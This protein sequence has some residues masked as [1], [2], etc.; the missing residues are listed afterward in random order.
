MNRHFRRSL[1]FLLSAGVLAAGIPPGALAAGSQHDQTNHYKTLQTMEYRGASTQFRSQSEALSTIFRRPGATTADYEV[2]T[3]G[4][5]RIGR[6]EHL[7]GFE[8]GSD[9]F[10][11]NRET[12]RVAPAGKSFGL[13]AR[14]LNDTIVQVGKR[15]QPLGRW[16][17][18]LTFGLT[19][20]FPATMDFEFSAEA[21]PLQGAAD[22]VVIGF[23]SRR[24][25]TF[26]PVD[27][28]TAQE[29]AS[30]LL[31]G[32]YVWSPSQGT[33]YQSG[34]AFVA[35]RG[36]ETL[37]IEQLMLMTDPKG[38]RPLFIPADL[39]QALGLA[40]G[41]MAVTNEGDL[42]LW[43]KQAVK[44]GEIAAVAGATSAER[45]TNDALAMAIFGASSAD[46]ITDCSAQLIEVAGEP[47]AAA[48]TRQF[49]PSNALKAKLKS[50]MGEDLGGLAGSGLDLAAA[51]FSYKPPAMPPWLVAFGGIAEWANAAA[52]AVV[53]LPVA[54]EKFMKDMAQAEV[55][56]YRAAYGGERLEDVPRAKLLPPKVESSL[57]PPLP[58]PGATAPVAVSS[59]G[60]GTAT[61]LPWVAGGA[62]AVAVLG[63]VGSGGGG[64]DGS[65]SGGNGKYRLY[66]GTQD[67]TIT[68]T[69]AGGRR[70]SLP[71]ELVVGP[72]GR[73]YFPPT[74]WLSVS[75]SGDSFTITFR[76]S[77]HVENDVVGYYRGTIAQPRI[78]G[79]IDGTGPKSTC[80]GTFGVELVGEY[81]APPVQSPEKMPHL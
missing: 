6:H 40:T 13:L 55:E 23:A 57:T 15:P 30:G 70:H 35:S 10:S 5:V 80:R 68:F 29:L 39:R 24:P 56:I 50:L 20:Y 67:Y 74:P 37:R 77:I 60:G 73:L 75:Q 3:L 27:A 76:G 49:S 71:L 32:V 38:E 52:T 28:G 36:Q 33:M 34:T 18:T 7:F 45:G 78:G 14:I 65:G 64:G 79:T 54:V 47:E 9:G 26:K 58:T 17:Q 4:Q 41:P 8:T 16:Q 1:S 22:A 44:V 61:Y 31:R 25:F 21:F 59:P 12:D 2:K 69:Y 72:D 62:A 11:R 53:A 81:D 19:E 66:R 46:A 42:P 63:V 43:A 48:A 51:G